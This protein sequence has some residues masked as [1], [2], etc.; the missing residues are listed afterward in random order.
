MLILRRRDEHGSV[1]VAMTIILVLTALATIV[2]ARVESGQTSARRGFEQS[3]AMGPADA[4]VAD[5]LVQ[6]DQLEEGELPPATFCVGATS[7]GAG[8]EVLED[9]PSTAYVA[10]YDAEEDTVTV[11]SRGEVNG[12]RAG[13]EAVIRRGKLYRFAIFGVDYVRFN[14]NSGGQITTVDANGSQVDSPDADAGSNGDIECKGSSGGGES[15]VGESVGDACDDP[16]IL[17][18]GTFNP[19]PPVAQT[20]CST[21][22]ENVPATPCYPGDPAIENCPADGAGLLPAVLEPGKYLCNRMVKFR[23]GYTTINTASANNGGVVQ[24]FVMPPSGSPV[25]VDLKN[26]YVNVN[27]TTGDGDPTDLRVYVK[28]D[29]Q[30]TP[31]PGNNARRFVGIMYA[32]E[33][34]MTSD[35]CKVVW[36]GAITFKSIDCNGGPNLTVLYDSRVAGLTDDSWKVRNYRPAPSSGVVLP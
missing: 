31:G 12:Q 6:L 35:G 27:P 1:V 14:G 22:P 32:P 10:T 28:G 30:V 11:R 18:P 3:A 8:R 26:A 5:V 9:S 25:A 15:N 36:R 17:E 16:D 19:Q 33:S 23:E 4:G 34:N 2:L 21:V 7:C 24:L 13:V 29:G 20:D